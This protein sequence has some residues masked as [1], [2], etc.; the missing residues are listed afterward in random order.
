MLKE[1]KEEEKERCRKRREDM[2][3]KKQKHD[4]LQE[5]LEKEKD[6]LSKIHLITS[7]NELTETLVAI[8]KESI[9]KS[10]KAGKVDA[11]IKIRKKILNQKIHVPFSHC[12]KQRPVHEI[13]KDFSFF[14]A[15]DDCPTTRY[16]H[17]PSL[18]VGCSIKHKFEIPET[19]EETWFYGSVMAYD[20]TNNLHEI[21][22]TLI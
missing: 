15:E 20:S 9:S 5:R 22:V 7:P 1:F 21:T 3:T 10:K 14:I 18:L 6:K 11:L 12:R 16:L 17:N 2:L 13:A 19:G 4:A 8:D